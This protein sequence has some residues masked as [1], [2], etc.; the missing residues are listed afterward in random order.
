[1][2]FFQKRGDSQAPAMPQ[3]KPSYDSETKFAMYTELLTS[4]RINKSAPT[5]RG[6]LMKKVRNAIDSG[7]PIKLR[8]F[9]GGHKETSGGI[10]DTVDERTIANLVKLRKELSEIHQT[11]ISIIFCDVHAAC[12]NFVPEQRIDMYLRSLAEIAKMGDIPIYTASFVYTQVKLPTFIRIMANLKRFLNMYEDNFEED[13]RSRLV[14]LK[15]LV[16][17]SNAPLSKDEKALLSKQMTKHSL[18]TGML[19]EE[20]SHKLYIDLNLTFMQM[21]SQEQP[22]S[23]YV[24]F[25]TAEVVSELAGNSPMLHWYPFKK[26][27]VAPWYLSET[28]L[29]KGSL[30]VLGVQNTVHWLYHQIKSRYE[31]HKTRTKFLKGFVVFCGLAFCAMVHNAT[32]PH[33]PESFT[34]YNYLYGDNMTRSYMRSRKEVPQFILNMDIEKLQN[35]R[36]VTKPDAMAIMKIADD[37][38]AHKASSAYS[39]Y[40]HAG[41]IEPD[42]IELRMKMI[43]AGKWV[44]FGTSDHSYEETIISAAI[45]ADRECRA[46]SGDNHRLSKS[47]MDD[48]IGKPLSQACVGKQIAVKPSS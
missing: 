24:S 9:W 26:I 7:A 33:P 37:M 45:L 22:D 18:Q 39:Y 34:V 44:A 38:L 12:I 29:A 21:V 41:L 42:S 8:V 5:H 36:D 23:I 31:E 3:A 40:L 10:A 28:E 14:D 27:K 17:G 30:E 47:E 6:E 35:V 46:A 19:T 1:M 4:S 48:L 11:E 15:Y 32:V 13:T 16:H 2:A 20:E 25:G 43:E